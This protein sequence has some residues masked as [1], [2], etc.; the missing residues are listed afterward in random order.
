LGTLVIITKSG[1]VP[2]VVLG[3]FKWLNFDVVLMG[4][5]DVVLGIP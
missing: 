4:W 3:Y 2:M 5:Y 1:P